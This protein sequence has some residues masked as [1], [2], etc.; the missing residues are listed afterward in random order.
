MG[1][2]LASSPRMRA[3]EHDVRVP[4]GPRRGSAGLV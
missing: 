2:E 1:L 4:T 3:G